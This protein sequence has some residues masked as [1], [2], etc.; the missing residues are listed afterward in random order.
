MISCTGLQKLDNLLNKVKIK[1]LEFLNQIFR[2]LFEQVK[3]KVKESSP[4]LTRAIQFCPFLIASLISVT[5]RSDIDELILDENYSDIIVEGIETLVLFSGEKEFQ[6]DLI[7][8]CRPLIV[9]VGLNL[10]RTTSAELL[11]M[12]NDPDSF[13][14]LALDTCDKQKSRVV[15]TQGAKLV[16]ALCD[17]VDGAVSFVTLF[18]CQSINLALNTTSQS[19]GRVS[20]I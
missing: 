14:N 2:Y 17:N 4:F 18:C 7:K 9:D 13:V 10:M 12:V 1:A 11:E 3:S 6:D 20:S 16:E 19:D 15:K 5:S 8:A